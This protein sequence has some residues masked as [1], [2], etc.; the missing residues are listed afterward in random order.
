[1]LKICLSKKIQKSKFHD[2]TYAWAEWVGKGYQNDEHFEICTIQIAKTTNLSH[3][4]GQSINFHSQ[5][6]KTR[7]RNMLKMC[8]VFLKSEPRYA[9][10]R[11]AYNASC[12]F[13]KSS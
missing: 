8:L 12:K 7:L 9:Y 10:K 3:Q 2:L 6:T 4:L 1:M 5:Y 13:W 11:Y